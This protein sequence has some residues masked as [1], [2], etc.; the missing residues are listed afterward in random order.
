M[1]ERLKLMIK[2]HFR[3]GVVLAFV[4]VVIVGVSLHPWSSELLMKPA[5]KELGFALNK[6]QPTVLSIPKLNLETT[7]E[8]PLGLNPD[9]SA[10]VPE[11]YTKV[12]WYKHGPTPGELGP[13]VIL[14]HVDSFAG[15]AVFFSLGQLVIG[16]DIFVT[17]DDGSVAQFKVSEIERNEQT[18][19]PT[20]KV[21]GDL[22][23]AGLRLITC[24]G[25]FERGEQRY[26]HNLIVYAT[27]VR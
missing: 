9:G 23:Y 12:G 14:G 20:A 4:A 3:T 5:P 21:Y 27:L 7:F 17:R 10:V 1:N 8:E 11:S 25:T 6:A 22:E 26:S 15:P 16:D 2:N 19:F 13:A 18:E 24:T